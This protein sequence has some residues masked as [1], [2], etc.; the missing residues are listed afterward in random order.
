[1]YFRTVSFSWSNLFVSEF[2][3]KMPIVTLF[4][5]IKFLIFKKW[6]QRCP[7]D[8]F[9]VSLLNVSHSRM[10]IRICNFSFKKQQR[11]KQIKKSKRRKENIS[12]KSIKKIN[13]CPPGWRFFSSLAFRKQEYFYLFIYLFWPSA[14]I[15]YFIEYKYIFIEYGNNI[16]A[17]NKQSLTEKL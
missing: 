10:S 4:M 15:L 1:M 2:M 13:L 17:T 3:F 8:R 14:N 7:I 5:L 6:F 11:N 16:F 9:V 12:G